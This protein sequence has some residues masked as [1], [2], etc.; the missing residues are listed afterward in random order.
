MNDAEQTIRVVKSLETVI[1][2]SHGVI[3]KKV[4]EALLLRLEGNLLGRTNP[5]QT[6]Y[7]INE[8]YKWMRRQLSQ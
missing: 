4:C 1:G 6:R 7:A 3:W 8:I 5:A 2:I